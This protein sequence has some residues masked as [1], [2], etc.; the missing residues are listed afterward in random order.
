MQPLST[1]SKARRSLYLHIGSEKTGTATLHKF[2]AGNPKE[3]DRAGFTYF[4]GRPLYYSKFSHAHSPIVASFFDEPP[5]FIAPAKHRPNRELLE[6]LKADLAKETRNVILSSEHFS[7]R[8]RS[9]E[10][11]GKLARALGAFEVRVVFYTRSQYELFLSAYSTAIINGRREPFS[12]REIDINN[13]YLNY[14]VL[15][16]PW[17]E[18][19]GP[20]NI[21]V[22]D[23]NNLATRDVCDDFLSLLGIPDPSAFK[24]FSRNNASL[25]PER[26]EIIRRLNF[27]LPRHGEVAHPIYIASIQLRWLINSLLKIFYHEQPTENT[28]LKSKIKAA[29]ESSN[30]QLF[31]T[32][33][34]HPQPRPET[35]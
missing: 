13:P 24:K 27:F 7:S 35:A 14:L 10:S 5:D 1:E 6:Q 17:S 12:E 9:V 31:K 23:Y 34:D 28:A 11:I 32:Y 33:P 4:T 16:E 18:V 21:I 26:A 2:L 15:L 25:T 3:L 29:F 8:L 19:F 22:R 30:T 20:Q